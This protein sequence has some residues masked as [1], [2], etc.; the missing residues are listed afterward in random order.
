MSERERREWRLLVEGLLAELLDEQVPL[1]EFVRVVDSVRET[2]FE[3]LVTGQRMEWSPVTQA[4][5]AALM[6]RLF[7]RPVAPGAEVEPTELE[8][9]EG[10]TIVLLTDVLMV[11]RIWLRQL[12]GIE[13]RNATVDA[14]EVQSLIERVH[15]M[16][17]RISRRDGEEA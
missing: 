4:A 6:A 12:C 2:V 14:E 16:I 17:V 7:A 8:K 15:Q 5:V 3:G 1:G 10:E 9:R 13:Q 11:L